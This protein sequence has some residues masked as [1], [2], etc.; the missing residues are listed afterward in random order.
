MNSPA[1]DDALVETHSAVPALTGRAVAGITRLSATGTVRAR[2]A[3][4]VELGLLSPGEQLPS[5]AETARA[6]GVSEITARRALK[7][8]ADSGVVSR[9]RG[10]NGGTFVAH[11]GT[12]VEEV[13]RYRADTAEV[14]DLINQRALVE[15]SLAH[16][17]ALNATPEQVELLAR[18]VE[19]AA[20]AANWTDY[21]ASDEQFHLGVAAASG[22]DWALP[23]YTDVL[24]KLYRYFLPYPITRLHHANEDHAALVD[25]IRNHD[26]IAAVEIT[27]RHILALHDTMFVG[28]PPVPTPAP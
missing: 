4:A 27:T 18:R 6:L 16:H 19:S 20:A 3:L 5:D 24:Y 12:G 26:P 13:N 14:H 28:L 2:I 17:A 22:L 15:S 7:S 10:R 23:H 8:L 9:R 1:D 21:H 25:A 11:A